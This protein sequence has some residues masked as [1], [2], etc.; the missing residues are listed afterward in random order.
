M[1]SEAFLPFRDS[2]DICAQEGITAIVQPGWKHKRQGGHIRLRRARNSPNIHR[3]QTLQA[4][5]KE[6]QSNNPS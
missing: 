6:Y 2:V 1:A 4:L 5:I 3:N